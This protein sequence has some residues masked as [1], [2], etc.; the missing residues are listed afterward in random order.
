MMCAAILVVPGLF[1]YVL[2]VKFGPVSRRYQYFLCHAKAEAGC[3]CRL[4]KMELQERPQV[5]HQYHMREEKGTQPK[6][7][8]QDIL[9]W[10]GGFPREGLKVRYVQTLLAGYPGILLGY[11]GGVRKV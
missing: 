6:L 8:G 1:I 9:R 2:Y 11:P 10:G 3:F 5:L 7:L 4:L